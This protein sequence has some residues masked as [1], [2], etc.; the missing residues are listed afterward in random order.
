MFKNDV[1][2]LNFF[3][4]LK[5]EISSTVHVHYRVAALQNMS[6]LIYPHCV[7]AEET[8]CL[9]QTIIGVE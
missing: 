4:E 5:P 6:G 2:G 3:R 7:S 9:S 8:P 1:Q